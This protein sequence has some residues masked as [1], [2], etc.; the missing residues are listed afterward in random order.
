MQEGLQPGHGP[1]VQMVGRLV[2]QEQ[3]GRGEEQGG[4]PGVGLLAAGECPDDPVGGQVSDAQAVQHGRRAMFQVV[5]A[6][7]IELIAQL[8]V[9]G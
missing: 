4:Q 1:E 2:E 5:A 7:A 3:V 8:P 9:V 6:Q